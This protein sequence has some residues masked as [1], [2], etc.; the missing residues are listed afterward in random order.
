[1]G[2]IQIRGESVYLRTIIKQ[3]MLSFY[4]AVQDEEIRYMT[5]TKN[6]F[7]LEQLYEHYDRI[8]SDKTRYD[9]AICLVSDDQIIGDLSILDIEQTD[10][11]AG[12]RIS[13]HNQNYFN[14]GYGTEAVQLAL[15]FVFEK[16][17]LNRLQLEVYSHNIRGMKSY[18]KAG[19]K[20]EGVI[21]ESI[22]LNDVYFDEIIMGMLQKEYYQ[23]KNGTK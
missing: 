22:L 9:F 11:K 21:R 1:M 4:Q 6:I 3:D 17:N 20:R 19:F 16:I 10:R 13:L 8:S 5:G 18:E 12:F 15:A 2:E 23:I 7:S 14:K